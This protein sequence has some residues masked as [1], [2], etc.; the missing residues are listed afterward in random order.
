MTSPAKKQQK[1]RIHRFGDAQRRKSVR[2]AR[3][4]RT[5]N[6]SNDVWLDV[7]RFVGRA[8]LGEKV[9]LL[10][11][12]FDALVDKFN[13]GTKFSI[14]QLEIQRASSGRKAAAIKKRVGRKLVPQPFPQTQPPDSII[15]FT[16]I[17]ISYI[18]NNVVSFLLHRIKHLFNTDITLWLNIGSDQGRCWSVIKTLFWDLMA[19]NCTS[20]LIDGTSVDVLR[21]FISPTV[22]RDCAKLR[23][24]EIFANDLLPD[25]PADDQKASASAG[26]ALSKWLHTP[27]MDGRP[28]MFRSAGPAQLEQNLAELKTAFL[29]AIIPV[30]YI[31]AIVDLALGDDEPFEL[32]NG[33]TGERLTYRQVGDVCLLTRSPVRRETQNWAQWEEEAADW[34]KTRGKIVEFWISDRDLAFV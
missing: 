5:I 33:Q 16:Q 10:S 32:E 28:K 27:R 12:R 15:G 18:D 29:N 6:V 8:R 19:N 30:N 31:V 20:M 26:Q 2:I 17:N 3:R 7:F 21:T 24:I 13:E 9:A 34:Q 25:S 11:V 1:K 22:F 23:S 14:G 4:R